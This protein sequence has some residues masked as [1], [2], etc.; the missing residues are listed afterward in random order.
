MNIW[1]VRKKKMAQALQ[2]SRPVY[3]LRIDGW[4]SFPICTVDQFIIFLIYIIIH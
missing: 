1:E 3:M 2:L 4:N